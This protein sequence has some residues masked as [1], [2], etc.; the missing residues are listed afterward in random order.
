MLPHPV[1]EQPWEKVGVDYFTLAG[2]D[3]L[4]VVDY[5]SKYPEVLQVNGKTADMTITKMKSIFARHGIPNTVVADNMPFG[6]RAFQQFAKEW[7]FSIVTSS[8]TYA[9]SNGLA[10][11]NVQTIKRL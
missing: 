5:F 1:P 4:L 6:S 7:G 11:R 2:K 8:P 3:Y 10:E 9:Q